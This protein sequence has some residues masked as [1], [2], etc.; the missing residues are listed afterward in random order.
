MLI[1][2]L[3]TLSKFDAIGGLMATRHGGGW[4]LTVFKKEASQ[5]KSKEDCL[6]ELSR[7]GPRVFRTLD[8]VHKLTRGTLKMGF[9]V[10]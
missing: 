3:I 8:A 6:L 10:R 5:Q 7:G 2:E 9:D 1:Q 4:I